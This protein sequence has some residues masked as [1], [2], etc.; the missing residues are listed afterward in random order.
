MVPRDHKAAFDE[1]IG[2]LMEGN[3]VWAQR[4]PL[5][6]IAV[7]QT[8]REG[9]KPNPGALY[10]LGQAV[11]HLSIQATALGLV[12]H[13]MGGFFTDKVIAAF[14]IPDGYVPVTISAIGRQ[15][16]PDALP[17]PLRDRELAPRTRKP[18]DS[19]VFS[20]KWGEPS[21]IGAH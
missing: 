13:Q 11:A 18:L 7:A 9:G 8:V 4:A 17:A 20:S 21:E 16:D 12:V 6:L 1:A 15:G 3:I 14:N 5:L 2:C 10:D 19:F